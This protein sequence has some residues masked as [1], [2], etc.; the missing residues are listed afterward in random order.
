MNEKAMVC[1][2]CEYAGPPKKKTEGSFLLE[3]VLWILFIVP[4]LL[5]SIYRQTTRHDVCRQ[6]GA[7]VLVPKGSPRGREI[8][9][10]TKY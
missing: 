8:W 3:V 7:G 10:A 5:Y 4:G 9:T 1:M 6:C 2:V